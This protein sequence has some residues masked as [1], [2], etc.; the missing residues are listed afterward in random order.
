M[1]HWRANIYTATAITIL[2]V[3]FKIFPH[4][5][6]KFSVYF[7]FIIRKF[8]SNKFEFYIWQL[9]NLFSCI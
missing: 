6:L 5:S 4:P 9:N 3:D 7:F 8:S 2:A 1:T